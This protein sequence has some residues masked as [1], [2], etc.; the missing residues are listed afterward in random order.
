MRENRTGKARLGY[1]V[2]Y[3]AS[4]CAGL[5]FA[6]TGAAAQDS[7]PASVPIPEGIEGDQNIPLSL[8]THRF[9]GD[10]A[11]SRV[12][13]TGL[14]RNAFD[15]TKYAQNQVD[16]AGCPFGTFSLA[17]DYRSKFETDLGEITVS[18][19]MSREADSGFS[20]KQ[21][22]SR[23]HSGVV[24]ESALTTAGVQAQLA[25][26]DISISSTLGLSR[27]WERPLSPDEQFPYR[28]DERSGL[29]QS[30]SI[31]AK[32]LDD[33]ANSFTIDA[34]LDR[35]DQDFRYLRGSSL[36]RLLLASDNSTSLRAVLKLQGTKLDASLRSNATFLSDSH[37]RKLKLSRGG[38]GVEYSRRDAVTVADE[39]IGNRAS[40]STRDRYGI[41][42]DLYGIAPMLAFSDSGAA[43]FLPKQL[44]IALEKRGTLRELATGLQ[45]DR[46]TAIELTSLWQ[47]GLGTTI[48]NQRTENGTSTAGRTELSSNQLFVSHIVTIGN[49][50]IGADILRFSNS[51]AQG[52]LDRTAL[53][54]ANLAYRTK[55]GPRVQID[56][57]QEAMN[58]GGSDSEFTFADKTFQI[59]LELD[60]TPVLRRK[61]ERDDIYLSAAFRINLNRSDYELRLFDEVLDRETDT[62]NRQ[63]LML[64]FGMN[65]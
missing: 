33:G 51:T 55:N 24:R 43:Q 12:E 40:S 16:S 1:F 21:Q 48:L 35:A 56:I 29:S 64:T 20:L 19:G 18:F 2:A 25:G 14:C 10:G 4:A 42:L 30:H 41:T 45:R 13:G 46:K 31:K 8:G 9:S 52:Q 34:K 36:D 17:S 27:N 63:G 7:A 37:T 11:T 50:D 53:Y 62:Y 58:F 23:P 38:I 61:L 15:L 49:W 60:M 65:L 6:A 44:G 26:G 3:S 47:T 22:L 32:L 54:S 5:A 59:G 28:F 39:T 57:G